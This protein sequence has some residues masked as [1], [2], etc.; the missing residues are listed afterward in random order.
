MQIP[1]P[2]LAERLRRFARGAT[3]DLELSSAPA[4]SP[5]VRV[6]RRLLAAV[7]L[8]VAF[9]LGL[10]AR[11]D[12]LDE[13]FFRH[14]RLPDVSVPPLREFAAARSP[15]CPTPPPSSSMPFARH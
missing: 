9:D 3:D 11:R 14:Y 12:A 8:L 7:L 1:R 6:A 2:T 15:Q 10:W 5:R 13:A 4:S